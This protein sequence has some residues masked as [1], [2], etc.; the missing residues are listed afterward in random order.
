MY[1]VICRNASADNFIPDITAQSGKLH[2]HI[3]SLGASWLRAPMMERF[4]FGKNSLK[5]KLKVAVLVHGPKSK[6][7]IFIQRPV[8]LPTV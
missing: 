8:S 5:D 4:L 6:N 1:V 2:G 7:T 3:R